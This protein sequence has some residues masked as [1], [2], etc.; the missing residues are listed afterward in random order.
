[1]TKRTFTTSKQ[2]ST[3]TAKPFW[4]SSTIIINAIPLLILV[5]DMVI[6]V[7]LVQDKDILLILTGVLNILNRIR[8][9]E[10]RPLKLR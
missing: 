9:V 10:K 3:I 2:S 6:K 5:I 4:Q 8:P 7:D 1:M